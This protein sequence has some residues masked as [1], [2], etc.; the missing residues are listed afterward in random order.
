MPEHI[1]TP[2]VRPL[3]EALL[4]L[5]RSPAFTPIPETASPYKK[6][7][8][9]PQGIASSHLRRLPSSLVPGQVFAPNKSRAGVHWEPAHTKLY[10]GHPR[11]VGRSRRPGT[12]ASNQFPGVKS[13]RIQPWA[14]SNMVLL[15]GP[16]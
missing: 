4:P 5:P 1:F 13:S 10:R 7:P 11:L 16:G 3:I 12:E 9:S 14:P 2:S 6:S 8:T 15:V